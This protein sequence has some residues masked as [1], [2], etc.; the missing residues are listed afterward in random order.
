[1]NLDLS[2]EEARF[3]KEVRSFLAETL[4]DELRRGQAL[5]SG[6]FPEPQISRP[7]HKAL[8]AR[9]WLAPLWPAD[10]GGTGW[11]GVQRFIFEAECALAGAP[12][13]FPMGVRLV[14]PVIIAFGSEAQRRYYLP[15][16]LADEDYWCQGFSEPGAGSDLAALS[17]RAVPDGDDYIV[18]GSKIW[19]SHAHHANRMFALVRTDTSGRKQEGISF[20]VID[21]DSPGIEIRPIRSIGGGHEINQV[22]LDDVRVPQ[23]NRIGEAGMGW[24][25]AKY[26][27]DFERGAGLFSGRLRASLKRIGQVM[28][29]RAAE[30][31]THGSALMAQFAE[32]AID[33]DTFEYLELAT[34]GPLEPGENPG[35]FASV[36]KLRASQLKQTIA[37]LGVAVLG[38]D[39]VVWADEVDSIEDALLPDYLNSRAATIFGGA[40]EIQLS[41]IAQSLAGLS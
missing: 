24:S 23:A 26:L 11:S 17:T 30:G 38:R 13:V 3:R 1:M 12:I 27:L 18:T 16:I 21:L 7:W 14:G 10:H 34:L 39:A 31:H 25:Y 19:T 29:A 32:A 6:V 40:K 28:R 8:G 41:L 15:R 20:L 35:P 5:L 33:V 36:L 37:A 22:F 4:T 9:G 2:P